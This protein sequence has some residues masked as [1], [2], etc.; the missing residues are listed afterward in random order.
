M[1]Q[2]LLILLLFLGALVYLG[3]R[4]YRLLSP[5]QTGC[6]KGCGCAG[7]Q[8]AVSSHDNK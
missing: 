4:V 2:E 5:K 6:G 8:P 1:G 3:Q 7:N